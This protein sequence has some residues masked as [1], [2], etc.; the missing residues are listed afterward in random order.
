MS[1]GTGP[2]SSIGSPITLMIRPKVS[3]P[4]GILMGNPESD[5]ACPRTKPS[6]PVDVFFVKLIYFPSALFKNGNKKLN[7]FLG[8]KK[9]VYFLETL[10]LHAKKGLL[11]I[12]KISSEIVTH[13][14]VLEK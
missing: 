11:G 12:A 4:T 7:F 8:K 1:V 10:E 13:F 6:V 9:C 2:R 5:T 14:S 3:A